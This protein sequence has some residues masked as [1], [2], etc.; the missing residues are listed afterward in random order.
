M[1]AEISVKF[2]PISF[3]KEKDVI[4][5]FSEATDS[6]SHLTLKG[7]PAHLAVGHDFQADAFLQSDGLVDGTIFHFFE[8][9]VANG[10]VRELLLS[11]KQRRRPQKAAHDVRVEGDHIEL[12]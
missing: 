5:E 1:V 2:V 6:G 3:E 11:L 9:D 8:L 10:A 7:L 4:G 12:D